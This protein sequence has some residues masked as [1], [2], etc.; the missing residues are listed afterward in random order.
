M[1]T[2]PDDTPA[3][4]DGLSFE[5]PDD[6]DIVRRLRLLNR[7]MSIMGN[8]DQMYRV[9]NGTI[10]PMG[11]GNMKEVGRHYM[12]SWL[13]PDDL[14][15]LKGGDWDAEVA[16]RKGKFIRPFFEQRGSDAS[17][18][19]QMEADLS[20]P[21]ISGYGQ[22][23]GY[24]LRSADTR[25]VMGF[26]TGRKAL[27][28]GEE[29]HPDFLARQQRILR[30]GVTG[31]IMKYTSDTLPREA[32]EKD[33]PT[34]MEIDTV[35]GEPFVVTRLLAELGPEIIETVNTTRVNVYH[36]YGLHFEPAIP[37]LL[38]RVGAN[39]RSE[40]FF[41]ALGAQQFAIDENKEGPSVT[42][43]IDGDYLNVTPVWSWMTA[44]AQRFL[45]SLKDKWRSQQRAKGFFKGK[46]DERA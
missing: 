1:S 31:G 29:I 44:P 38:T 3:S 14:R 37:Q 6:A 18:A 13:S 27:K 19:E 5:L 20:Y 11:K 32:L 9:L 33:I 28:H 12:N 8:R 36:L 2:T 41:D 25:Q 7:Q 21:N 24:V 26:I 17:I 22:Y 39:G 10:E 46:T 34:T 16:L 4:L 23:Y 30:N 35:A 45:D 15:R 42:H 40:H 43:K